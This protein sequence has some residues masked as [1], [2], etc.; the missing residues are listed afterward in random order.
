MLVN[1]IKPKSFLIFIVKCIIF[2]FENVAKLKILHETSKKS[3]QIKIFFLNLQ[4]I[5]QLSDQ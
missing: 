4:Q 3:L 2:V 1:R 5:L